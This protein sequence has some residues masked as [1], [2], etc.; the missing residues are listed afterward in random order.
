MFMPHTKTSHLCFYKNEPKE[1]L[2]HQNVYTI[3][4]WI[5]VYNIYLLMFL[6][7]KLLI[8]LWKSYQTHISTASER[9]S[10]IFFL[11]FT[12]FLLILKIRSLIV[13]LIFSEDK[14]SRQVMEFQLS[15]VLYELPTI[16][17]HL[18]FVLCANNARRDSYL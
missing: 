17:L 2:V 16:I 14:I 12:Y 3:G 9:Y 1:H 6:C 8:I 10:V 7:Q 11:P 5:D 4:K 15:Y 13:L 18:T